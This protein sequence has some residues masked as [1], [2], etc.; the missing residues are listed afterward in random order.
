MGGEVVS[1]HTSLPIFVA[2]V[3]LSRNRWMI[4]NSSQMLVVKKPVG[5]VE[6]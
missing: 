4:S 6:K 5:L 1:S 2:C 3:F